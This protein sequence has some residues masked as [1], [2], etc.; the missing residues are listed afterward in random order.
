MTTELRTPN[1]VLIAV[2]WDCSNSSKMSYFIC[3]RLD[4]AYN[5]S[6]EA[7]RTCS[8]AAVIIRPWKQ[9]MMV[10]AKLHWCGMTTTFR[11]DPPALLGLIS[12]NTDI[13][14][15]CDQN[16]AGLNVNRR[17]RPAP[18]HWILIWRR[19][20][21]HVDDKLLIDVISTSWQCATST[22]WSRPNVVGLN[23]LPRYS[24]LILSKRAFFTSQP[25]ASYFDHRFQ[26]SQMSEAPC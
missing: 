21:G 6:I 12:T 24:S 3:L 7:A 10:R 16:S 25:A 1:R 22:M 14:S 9:R 23:W 2:R 26:C 20:S 13:A 18:T 17:K 8:N 15:P 4:S 11:A 19:Q 5:R